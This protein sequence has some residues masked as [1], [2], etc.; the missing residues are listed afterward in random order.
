MEIDKAERPR[1]KLLE[2]GADSLGNA[3]LLAVILRSGTG[4]ESAL[5]L[6]HRLLRVSGGKLSVLMRQ[7]P[8]ALCSFKG[9]GPAKAA[10]LAA[11]AELGKRFLQEEAAPENKPIV[12]ARQVYNIMLPAVKSLDH[13]EFWALTLDSRSCLA[14]RF[15]ASS[16]GDASVSFDTRRL[17]RSILER[18]SSRVFL[19]HN[20]PSGN[21]LPSAADCRITEE[22]R[23]ALELVSVE[24]VDHIIIS[25][26]RF[27][28]FCD[29]HTYI[30]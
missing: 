26:S 7:S 20:H 28:S 17:I 18:G 13:E 11:A 30:R 5:E 24:L 15:R 6:S 16:G 2:R 27:Y 10:A 3:E 19:V 8:R 21:P 29:N 1:E 23:T 14:D 22:L 25:D 9:L 12:A 4:S